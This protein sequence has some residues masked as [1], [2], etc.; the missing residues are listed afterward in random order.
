M[1]SKQ[2]TVHNASV[3]TMTVEV[4]TLTIGARQVT[5]GIFRQLDEGPLIANDGTLNGIPWGR[6]N[7]CPDGKNCGVYTITSYGG[8]CQ[9]RFDAEHMHIVWQQGVN[10]YRSFVHS[11]DAESRRLQTFREIGFHGIR[12]CPW[13]NYSED[14][15]QR[16]RDVRATLAQLDQLFIGG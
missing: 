12:T 3:T 16:H 1:T 13:E 10:L 6:V 9:N 2:L 15:R 11:A 7:Y 14:V 8:D 5:L 4:K